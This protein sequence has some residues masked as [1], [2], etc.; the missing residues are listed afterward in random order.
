MPA[1]KKTKPEKDRIYK[2][3]KPV[4]MTDGILAWP[5]HT[6]DNTVQWTADDCEQFWEATKRLG[7]YERIEDMQAM[8][9]DL[10]TDN[11]AITLHADAIRAIH[12]EVL[13]PSKGFTRERLARLDEA[14][15]LWAKIMVIRNIMPIAREAVVKKA[16][17]SATNTA[18]AEKPRPKNKKAATAT[19][20]NVA[21]FAK[22]QGYPGGIKYELLLI[23][24]AE[25]YGVSEAT[26]S[27]RLRGK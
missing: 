15:A 23:T 25:H 10:P 27:R 8:L 6:F 13:A 16:K 4:V 1:P 5:N 24:A 9:A 22:K 14:S 2:A 12:A 19:V 21:A 20:E 18:S 3:Y 11:P 26:I 17:V 7:P